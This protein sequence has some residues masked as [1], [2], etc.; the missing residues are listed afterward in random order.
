MTPMSSTA[1]PE[2]TLTRPAA[3]RP[4][5]VL[6]YCV[7]G[8]VFLHALL[9]GWASLNELEKKPEEKPLEMVMVEV[10]PPQVEKV[11]APKEPPPPIRVARVDKP[12]AK[13]PPELKDAPPPPNDAPAP[14][15]SKPVPLVV[16]ISL[17]STTTAGDFAAA[18]GNTVYGR[19]E[20]TA[21]NPDEVKGYSAPKYA[22]AYQVDTQ[23]ELLSEVKAPYPEEAKRASIEGTVVLK[24]LVD[25]NGQVVEA[26]LLKGLG[27]GLDEAALR[28]IR[29]FKF[30]P[31]YKGGEAV[32]TEINYNYTWLLD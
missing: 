30:R 28:A 23:P 25:L 3:P 6:T 26:R 15:P 21:V 27:F 16:G 5:P 11:E 29:Q 31:A 13:P 32:S 17:S 7:V 18:T 24:I 9:L 4:V 1:L 2:D 8:S 10:E 12:V 22:P 20:K 19:T 14:E